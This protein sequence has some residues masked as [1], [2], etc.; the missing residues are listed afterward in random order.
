MNKLKISILILSSLFSAHLLANTEQPFDPEAEFSIT[1]QESDEINARLNQDK[2]KLNQVKAQNEARDKTIS[3]C[4]Q[5][6]DDNYTPASIQKTKECLSQNNGFFPQ[7]YQFT[8]GQPVSYQQPQTR[9][10]TPSMATDTPKNI[11]SPTNETKPNDDKNI[12][13]NKTNDSG[14]MGGLFR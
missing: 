9:T 3:L 5:Y 1:Q 12:Q 14:Y 10:V 4:S 2:A 13:K 6:L 8:E 7:E 11:Q